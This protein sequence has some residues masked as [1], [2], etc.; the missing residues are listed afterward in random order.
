MK[1]KLSI[2][3]K[4]GLTAVCTS[5]WE[6]SNVDDSCVW[7]CVWYRPT[8]HRAGGRCSEQSPTPSILTS[9][10]SWQGRCDCAAAASVT[11]ACCE[12]HTD[13]EP[14][15]RPSS[16]DT[17]PDCKHTQHIRLDWCRQ[18]CSYSRL[19]HWTDNDNNSNH[20][21][22]AHHCLMQQRTP[23]ASYISSSSHCLS[24][25]MFTYVQPTCSPKGNVLHPTSLKNLNM[26]L[27]RWIIADLAN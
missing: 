9:C 25:A 11:R 23:T 14:C 6:G 10:H 5:S 15:C 13:A 16:A 8:Q 27:E 24:T 18:C 2:S 20:H 3:D 17:T 4:R 12:L 22:T 1:L 26:L 7:R 19:S 21:W